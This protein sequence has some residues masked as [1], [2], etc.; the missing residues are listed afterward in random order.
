V[1]LTS[2]EVEE[3]TDGKEG[4]MKTAMVLLAVGL[5]AVAGSSEAGE[6]DNGVRTCARRTSYLKCD[7]TCY[8]K[9]FLVSLGHEVDGV[10]E[11]AIRE[12]T[13][14]KLVQPATKSERIR[15]KLEILATS[16]RTPAIR[17]KALLGSAV[18][19]NPG[20]FTAEGLVEYGTDDEVFGAIL[21][22]LRGTVIASG[23]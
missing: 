7:I 3:G 15:E 20:W 4:T 23:S 17:V 5:A 22:R 11:S 6:K 18:Y 19:E 10:V 13:L 8:E 12:V 9:G 21:A 1:A 16:G 2:P 14:I